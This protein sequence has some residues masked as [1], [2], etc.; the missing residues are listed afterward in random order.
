MVPDA[1]WDIVDPL[2][3]RFAPCRQGSGT[4]AVDER[5]VFTAIVF[6]LTSGCAW[7]HLPPSFGVSVP[8]AHRRF[9]AWAESGV[10]D[11][12]HREIL[13]RLGPVGW[14]CGSKPSTSASPTRPVSVQV[15]PGAKTA[16]ELRDVTGWCRGRTPTGEPMVGRST[17]TAPGVD[18]DRTTLHDQG[19]QT[20]ELDIEAMTATD[21]ANSLTSVDAVFVSG[22]NVFHLLAVLRRTGFADVLT[23]H[24]H[25]GRMPT[26]SCRDRWSSQRSVADTEST[27]HCAHWPTTRRCW[28]LTAPA[29]WISS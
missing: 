23:E 14:S 26:A 10:F 7:R 24:V 27:S 2:I 3:P 17:T 8:T 4:A 20:V 5:A 21:V 12:L 28:S 13:D 1:L 16:V 25:V 15:G 19:W 22:G 6:V 29:R 18:L 9:A 11:A